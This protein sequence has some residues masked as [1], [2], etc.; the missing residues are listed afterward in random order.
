LFIS[1]ILLTTCE[2]VSGGPDVFSFDRAAL[3]FGPASNMQK[4]SPTTAFST[5]LRFLNN[6]VFRL[7]FKPPAPLNRHFPY[8]IF[9][10]GLH[11]GYKVPPEAG[12]FVRQALLKTDMQ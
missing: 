4:H 7:E 9:K 12:R 5:G 1:T 11:G 3:A 8:F 10:Y 6:R 2:N